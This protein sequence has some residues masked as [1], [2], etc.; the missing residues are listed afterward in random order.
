MAVTRWYRETSYVCVHYRSRRQ[1][2]VSAQIPSEAIYLVGMRYELKRYIFDEIL[3]DN[4]VR[5]F[6]TKRGNL[7]A[8][9]RVLPISSPYGREI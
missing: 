2:G 9:Q 3:R 8:P 7:D 6:D 4:E 1:R 5:R